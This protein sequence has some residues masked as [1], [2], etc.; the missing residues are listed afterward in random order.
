MKISEMLHACEVDHYGD[1]KLAINS[2]G[3][4]IFVF[5]DSHLGPGLNLNKNFDGKENF[6]AD[7]SFVRFIDH[8]QTRL[9]EKRAILII[10]GDFIDFL[11]I[12]NFP[13]SEND[14]LCWQDILR[15]LG[16]Q[17]SIEEL[18][19]SVVP[20]EIKY[21]L[22]TND[23]KS[24][25]K[26]E[27]CIKGHQDLFERL[28]LWLE[29]G[30]KILIVK[31]NHD[32]EWY[33][34]AVRNFLR[35][36][37]AKYISTRQKR[38]IDVIINEVISKQLSFADN[39][40]VIDQII[41][42]EHG[43]RYENMT[44]VKGTP[45]LA[46][47]VELN[48]PF[49]SFFNRYLI[50]RLELAYP[51]L[52]NI[53][54]TGNVLA[55]LI[56]E[57]FPLAVQ[58][59]FNYIP[60]MILTIPKKLYWQTFKYFLQ[61]L[62]IIILPVGITIY[63]IWQSIHLSGKFTGSYVFQQL[64]SIAKNSGFLFLSYIFGRFLSMAKL[65]DSGSLVENAENVFRDNPQIRLISFGHTHNP[66]QKNDSGNWYFNTGT[67]IPVFEISS[68]DIRL[69]KSYTFLHLRAEPFKTVALQRWNDD[70]GRDEMLVLNDKS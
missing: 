70:A 40:V 27:K 62:F 21:G 38:N 57:R 64:I 22:K 23:F 4:E 43:H 13:E 35:L 69:D 48:L 32:L 29:D 50:N 45:V 1:Q 2:E 47:K 61:F 15:E 36:Y 42:L 55:V 63:A 5:S 6:F 12:T 31:G 59:L 39:A 9:T 58:L 24:V 54:P 26:L 14:F 16:I 25:W 44:A 30:N 17:K 46:N 7:A 67:W 37:F 8:L 19:K 66:E 11:R 49:G 56:R 20:K 68:A 33:W 34:E 51:Y 53:R 65:R 60:F 52:D 10:N 18:K 41:Y 3:R 28:A